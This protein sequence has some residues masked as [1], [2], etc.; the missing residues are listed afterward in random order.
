MEG[1]GH[2]GVT[3]LQNTSDSMKSEFDNLHN[4]ITQLNSDKH[5]MEVAIK[6]GEQLKLY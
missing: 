6:V 4:L 5:E 2:E 1:F 3:V